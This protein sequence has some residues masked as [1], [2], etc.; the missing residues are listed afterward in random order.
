MLKLLINNKLFDFSEAEIV[1]RVSGVDDFLFS[2]I[3]ENNND[4][5]NIQDFFL[6]QNKVEF[7]DDDL[8]LFT[9][10]T[11]SIDF[12]FNQGNNFKITAKGVLETLKNAKITDEFD[13]KDYN[14]VDILNKN[15]FGIKFQDYNLEEYQK[16]FSQVVT[17]DSYYQLLDSLSKRFGFDFW[18]DYSSQICFLGKADKVLKISDQEV[19]DG[20]I[21]LPSQINYQK[22][23]IVNLIQVQGG[24]SGL[25]GLEKANPELQI[26]F[27]YKVDEIIDK[28]SKKIV[29]F[30]K[31]NQSIKNYGMRQNLITPID[32]NIKNLTLEQQK[33]IS[34]LLYK[35]AVAQLNDFKNPLIIINNLK[36]Y[37][38]KFADRLSL[39]N[40]F[41]LDLQDV[42]SSF[43][44]GFKSKMQIADISFV[45]EGRDTSE[46]F[47][48]LS[49]VSFLSK[50]KKE[51]YVL[52][53]IL[54]KY[55]RLN[56]R[57]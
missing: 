18:F 40:V 31:D 54:G 43:F 12:S 5:F 48:N 2:P 7:F 10:F 1:W 19:L 39:F 3:L 25:L 36:F 33:E 22:D 14:I 35:V 47:Y 16:E 8:I 57:T 44:G 52:N 37:Q 45:F 20:K 26:K 30:I 29:Y 4:E 11:N 21:N 50:E 6:Y 38:I 17:N 15:D 53:R 23:R 13:F 41:D 56:N 32:I 49:L 34:T 55:N 46:G 51:E 9:G 24:L 28:F 27:G 42:S